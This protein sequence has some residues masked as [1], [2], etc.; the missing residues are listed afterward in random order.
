MYRGCIVAATGLV[1]HCLCL[2]YHIETTTDRWLLTKFAMRSI[3]LRMSGL[4]LV[5]TCERVRAYRFK[6]STDY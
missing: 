6:R 2:R 5:L 3:W 4:R 1:V